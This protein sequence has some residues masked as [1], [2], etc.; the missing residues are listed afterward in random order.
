MEQK[1]TELEK[2]VKSTMGA[3]FFTAEA[4]TGKLI[5]ILD[6]MGG[7]EPLILIRDNF[8]TITDAHRDLI[9]NARE[10]YPKA[11]VILLT[12]IESFDGNN[13]DNGQ[14]LSLLD[15]IS[16]QGFNIAITSITSL[17][18]SIISL[19]QYVEKK[20]VMPF[21]KESLEKLS[22]LHA[23]NLKALNVDLMICK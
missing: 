13:P 17:P 3:N 5:P 6:L 11:E 18:L 2:L 20:I 15:E 14:L 8:S 21:T 9:F 4:C 22:P 7:E 23:H 19:R 16:T 1:E 12:G 10:M